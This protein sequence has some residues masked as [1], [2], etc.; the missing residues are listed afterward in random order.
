MTV[1]SSVGVA[2]GHCLFVVQVGPHLCHQFQNQGTPNHSASQNFRVPSCSCSIFVFIGACMW[3]WSWALQLRRGKLCHTLEG[4]HKRSGFVSY[5]LIIAI[6]YRPIVIFI[7][8]FYQVRQR[9]AHMM[10]ES[11]HKQWPTEQ[12]QSQWLAPICSDK[13]GSNKPALDY[14]HSCAT[15]DKLDLLSKFWAPANFAFCGSFCFQCFSVGNKTP[16]SL[17]SRS[18]IVSTH[19][20]YSY[21]RTHT[22]APAKRFP[23][24]RVVRSTDTK[25][26]SSDAFGHCWQI[27]FKSNLPTSP[28]LTL[29]QW[30][31]LVGKWEETVV[32]F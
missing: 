19:T 10:S 11:H 13:E 14:S 15:S 21:T 4:W 31:C 28:V 3:Q 12:T 20:R 23:T 16:H 24:I 29:L 1:K 32:W 22:H 8:H 7:C 25:Y 9:F 6:S 26:P 27:R 17:C 5:F 2:P 18:R 30:L